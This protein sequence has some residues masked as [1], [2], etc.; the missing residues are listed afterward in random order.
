MIT[1]IQSKFVLQAANKV[2][3]RAVKDGGKKL[4]DANKAVHKARRL[5]NRA[6]D[7]EEDDSEALE[8]ADYDL[9]LSAA[10]ATEKSISINSSFTQA[11]SIPA[12]SA[13]AWK[14]RVKR[15]DIGFAVREKGENNAVTDIEIMTRY[16]SDAP[17]QGQLS[18]S[19]YNRNII[20]V[21]D[22]SHSHLQAKRV[23]YW[24]AIGENVSL[25]DDAVGAARSLEVAAAEEGPSDE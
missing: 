20:L 12:G 22:N 19:S 2:A 5:A 21:L 16:R 4:A 15:Y 13:F 24:L 7:L 18:A 1:H 14:V 17:I 6:L 23:V 8:N 25:A 9:L 11:I 3:T 10:G